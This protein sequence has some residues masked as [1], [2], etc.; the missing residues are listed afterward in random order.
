MQK[1]RR[2]DE[3]VRL[4][5]VV[6]R[7]EQRL[8]LN[9]REML[10]DTLVVREH[11]VKGRAG[12]HGLLRCMLHERMRIEPADTVAERKHHSFAENQSVSEIGRASCGKEC[13]SRWSPYH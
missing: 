11:V 5:G 7:V 3:S 12:R 9:K 6:R 2:I 1:Q 8:Q 4:S 10:R 13:R